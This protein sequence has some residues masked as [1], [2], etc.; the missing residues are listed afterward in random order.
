MLFIEGVKVDDKRW[1]RY[2]KENWKHNIQKVK[3]F[4]VGR[5]TRFKKINNTLKNKTLNGTN[6]PNELDTSL[7]T[8]LKD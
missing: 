3:D 5:E 8:S 2:P 1:K 4:A 7:E 6:P